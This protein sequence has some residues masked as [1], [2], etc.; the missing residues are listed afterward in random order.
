[1]FIQLDDT[2]LEIL[3]ALASDTRV[4]IIHSLSKSPSTVSKLAETLGLSK[5]IV[6]R[7]VRLLEDAGLI[8]LETDRI[9]SD[10]RVKQFKLAVDHI[11]V[12]FPKKIH[13]PYKEIDTEIKLGYFSNFSVIP[14]CGLAS[15]NATIGELD[16]PRTFVANERIN[17]S[18]LWFSDGFVEYVVPNQLPKNAK[19]ELLELS[20][21][22]SSEF[23]ESNN[24]WPSDISFYI[25]DTLLGTW[26]APGNYSD[27]RGALTP[28]WWESGFSQYGV[29]K[30]L[31]I[32]HKDS[33]IDGKHLSDIKL[34]DLKLDSSPF[35][36]VRIGI[37]EAA[38][39]RG[40]LTI[41]G[42]EF[43]NH[44]QNILLR[45]FYSENG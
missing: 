4:K 42:S 41:F 22:I 40:G 13:L 30:H 43:G 3:K 36:K 20:L 34:E 15:A 39:N 31:R 5:A 24:N 21:E 32:T 27:V 16:D 44:P 1:M 10:Q 33:G 17:A 8:Y 26:T 14:T 7:H 25:N 38:E 12:D 28:K 19:L 45:M 29:L 35:I 18:L 9:F 23:P 6:S 37:D 2:G 11:E